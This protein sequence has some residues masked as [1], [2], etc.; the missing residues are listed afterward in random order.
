MWGPMMGYGYGG[1][2]TMAASGLF[3]LV[4]LALVVVLIWRLAGHSTR[5][6]PAGRPSGLEVLDERYA[7][8][9]VQ[10]D[11]YLQKRADLTQPPRP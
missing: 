6:Q 1:G 2:W 8:G 11:E 4:I 3:W 9:E 10:R 7:R 5:G